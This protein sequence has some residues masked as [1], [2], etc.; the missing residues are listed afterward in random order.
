MRIDSMPFDAAPDAAATGGPA[1]YVQHATLAYVPSGRDGTRAVLKRMAQLVR[2][3]K[4]D[5]RIYELARQIIAPVYQ[6]RRNFA[7]MARAVQA[8]V[9]Q[10]IRVVDDPVDMEAIQEPWLTVQLQSGDCDDHAILV[11]ALLESVGMRARF[12][13]IAFEPDVFSHVYTEAY[14]PPQWFALETTEPWS[15][16]QEAPGVVDHMQQTI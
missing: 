9:Q 16:G 6:G 2:Q 7:P 12:Q 14:V 4:A 5:G 15:F 13:A 11:A 3:G 1:G 8:W 10:H